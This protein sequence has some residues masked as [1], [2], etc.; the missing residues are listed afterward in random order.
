MKLHEEAA[1]IAKATRRYYRD[2]ERS[3]ATFQQ[4]CAGSSQAG[5]FQVVLRNVRGE[6]ARY[7]LR[8]TRL[9]LVAGFA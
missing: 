4:P 1:L 7:R 6:I 3:G 2:C 8:G 9:M 5:A